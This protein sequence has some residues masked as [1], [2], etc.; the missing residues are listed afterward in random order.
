MSVRDQ[1]ISAYKEIMAM[2]I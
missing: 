2:P 1:V